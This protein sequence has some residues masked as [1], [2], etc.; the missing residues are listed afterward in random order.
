MV[1]EGVVRVLERGFADAGNPDST[2]GEVEPR[3]VAKI[4]SNSPGLAGRSGVTREE[5]EACRIA[6][7]P[8]PLWSRVKMPG[9]AGASK[10]VSGGLD[11]ALICTTN[12]AEVL[13]ASS[14]GTCPLICVGEANSNGA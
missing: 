3:P 12:C 8:L 6:P 10:T 4:S 2:A 13:P 5:S 1:I 11:T 9:A 14:T 7:A